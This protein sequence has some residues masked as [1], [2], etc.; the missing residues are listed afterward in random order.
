MK[1]A[2]IL[3]VILNMI[4]SSICSQA[5]TNEAD[6]TEIEDWTGRYVLK[7]GS[8]VMRTKTAIKFDATGSN[9]Y[10]QD[11]YSV[12]GGKIIRVTSDQSPRLIYYN[13]R[14][15]KMSL[16]IVLP[17]D[18]SRKEFVMRL[19]R[20]GLYKAT[21]EENNWCRE[22]ANWE[23]TFELSPT[24]TITHKPTELILTRNSQ[25]RTEYKKGLKVD[26][27]IF[28]VLFTREEFKQTC[29][30]YSERTAITEP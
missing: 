29:D 19:K 23:E 15:N 24:M 10:A 14:N 2:K 21:E 27:V 1:L 8:V 17:F 3:F 28:H 7:D 9:L 18:C 16:P 30:R 6:F 4:I 13:P 11:L 22:L 20:T 5:A 26:G 12:R 25:D